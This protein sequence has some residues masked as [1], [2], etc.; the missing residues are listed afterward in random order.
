MQLNELTGSGENQEWKQTARWIKYEENLEEGAD[1]WGRPHVAALSFHSLLN[2]RHCLE[3]GVVLMNLE[4]NDLSI[5]AHRVVEQVGWEY[6]A[7]SFL[8]V[9]TANTP[10]F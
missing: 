10:F 1:R 2:L 9:S 5:V 3:T 8:K 7:Y 4:A 6:V